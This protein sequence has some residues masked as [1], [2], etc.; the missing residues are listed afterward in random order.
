[1]VC[2]QCEAVLPDEA[3]FCPYCM[4]KIPD[5]GKPEKK[6]P[7]IKA[8]VITAVILIMIAVAS[9]VFIPKFFNYKNEKSTIQQGLSA[10]YSDRSEKEPG[11]SDKKETSTEERYTDINGETVESTLITDE[12]GETYAPGL[13]KWDIN[14]DGYITLTEYYYN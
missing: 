11:T 4:T 2:R 8:T 13:Y 14:G 7:N 9:A 3:E 1:M 12:Y 5:E 10:A 6:E